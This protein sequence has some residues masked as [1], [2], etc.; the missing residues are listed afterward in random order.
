MSANQNTIPSGHRRPVFPTID[1]FGNTSLE[2]LQQSLGAAVANYKDF[3]TRTVVPFQQPWVLRVLSDTGL[4]EET[5]RAIKSC[6][7]TPC[8]NIPGTA[9]ADIICQ[10]D[11]PIYIYTSPNL[12]SQYVE[13]KAL[14][15][16]NNRFV[17]ASS[18]PPYRTDIPAQELK[19][20]LNS[21]LPRAYSMERAVSCFVA[22]LPSKKFTISTCKITTR[23]GA[24]EHFVVFSREEDDLIPYDIVAVGKT[25]FYQS[26]EEFGLPNL[27]FDGQQNLIST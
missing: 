13:R 10:H 2:E 17:L 24:D 14:L 8:C 6:V 20:V 16:C 7:F 22:I 5:L 27:S 9:Q 1:L 12:L 26:D 25:L 3:L 23:G 21:I 15:R 18:I 4:A 11:S 19:N